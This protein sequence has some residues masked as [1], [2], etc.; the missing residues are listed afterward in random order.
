[1]RL[2]LVGPLPPPAGGMANQT[3]QLAAL[4][5]AEGIDVRLVRTNEPCRLAWV[6]A[7]RGVREVFRFMSYVRDVASLSREVDVLH[8]MANSG[9]SWHLR[10]APAIVR[11]AMRGVP[12]IVNYRGGLAREFLSKSGSGVRAMLRLASAVVVPSRFLQEI[13]A[14]HGVRAEIIPNIV[15]LEIFRPATVVPGKCVHI[16][17]ARNLERLYGIDVAIRAVEKLRKDFPDLV[18]SVAGTGRERAELERLS[19]QLGLTSVV[20]FTGGLEVAAVAALYREAH[21]VLNPSRADNTP[22]ALLEAAASGVPIVSTDV[23]GIPY[24]V[25]H[26][27]SAWLVPPEDPEALAAGVKLVLQDAALREE[28]R[29]NALAVARS[30]SWPAVRPQWLEL[31]GRADRRHTSCERAAVARTEK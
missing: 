29:A 6:R 17:V 3:R 25:E 23:G 30:C 4:L 8:V 22:N 14:E 19:A 15:D 1:M 27:R 18:V 10:A 11:G 21:V 31:Y 2:G 13:F 5:R 20:R 16:V 9:L 12:V 24:L 7:V 28:L 26:R